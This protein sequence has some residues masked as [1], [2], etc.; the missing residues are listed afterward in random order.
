M[1]V[2]YSAEAPATSTAPA[3]TDCEQLKAQLDAAEADLNNRAPGLQQQLHAIAGMLKTLE[4][5]PA[6][7]P[8]AEAATH[9]D[10]LLADQKAVENTLRSLES[11]RTAWRAAL[12]ACEATARCRQQLQQ[13]HTD[14]ERKEATFVSGDLIAIQSQLAQVQSARS[15]LEE[16]EAVRTQRLAG[17]TDEIEKAGNIAK[18]ALLAEQS[19]LQAEV[20]TTRQ[21]RAALDAERTFLEARLNAAREFLGTA[22]TQPATTST[23]PAGDAAEALA[24]QRLAE[25]LEAEARDRLGHARNRLKEIQG[26]IEQASSAGHDTAQLENDREYWRRVEGYEQNRLKLAELQQRAAQEKKTVAQVFAGLEE[27]R[28]GLEQLE[29]ARPK[30]SPEER[31][32]QAASFKQQAAAADQQAGELD[33]RAVAAAK[34]I[35]PLQQILPTLDA[36]DQ[37]LEERLEQAIASPEYQRIYS[38]VRRMKRQ[39]DVERQQTGY[40]IATMEVIAFAITRQATLQRRLADLY[41]QS[42][43]I[44]VPPVPSFWE[45]NQR[46][47]NAI[48]IVGLV[49]ALTY[50]V[51]LVVWLIRRTAAH[52]NSKLGPGRLSVKRVGTL[53]SFAASI[54]KLFLWVFGVI[55]VLNEFGIN[56]AASTGAIGLIGLIMAGMFQQVVVDFVKGLD[57]I[58]GQHYNVGDFVEVAGKVGHVVDFNAKYTCIRTLSGAE[59]NIP[60]SQCVPSRRFP[61][62][63]INNYVD[64]TLKSPDDEQKAREVIEPVCRDLNE[65]IEAIREEPALAI[66]FEGP[67]QPTTLRYRVRVLPGCDWV[68]QDYFIPAARKALADAGIEL[69]NEPTSLYINRIETFRKLFSRRLNE[70]EIVRDVADRGKQTD[71]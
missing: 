58:A 21:R 69:A 70:E 42:A 48:K 47:I 14:L 31:Q 6:T 4:T 26:Q 8:A 35:E 53:V 20:E 67:G 59:F 29:Q 19:A 3:E 30:M 62:G 51:K 16:T 11:A 60:N 50:V 40:M 43:D 41:G 1:P 17:L 2:A 63:Y 57:I 68:V 71:T 49:V 28:K 65:R 7:M 12:D 9:K 52:L 24:R 23:A 39:L 56:P 33:Q 5:Q 18:S 44:L 46:V 25:Q 27:I 54:V 55:W 66:R 34:E 15:A 32:Q 38:H 45:R 13:F 36:L 10:K 64:I 22:T 37:A 61:D